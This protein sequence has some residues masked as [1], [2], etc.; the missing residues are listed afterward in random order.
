M[1]TIKIKN[2]YLIGIIV[3]II[4]IIFN[5]KI[6]LFGNND[7]N[8]NCP[9]LS[10][11][12]WSD[13]NGMLHYVFPRTNDICYQNDET[14]TFENFDSQFI[15]ITTANYP[16]ILGS[17]AMHVAKNTNY[18]CDHPIFGERC[19]SKNNYII[20]VSWHKWPNKITITKKQL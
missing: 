9:I 18:K 3:I 20:T 17:L 1:K 12:I 5:F 14:I 13:N 7:N 10:R 11:T 6:T 15:Q 2:C 8:F 16:Q 19:I 4:I